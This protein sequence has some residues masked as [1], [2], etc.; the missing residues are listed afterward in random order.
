MGK[1]TERLKTVLGW[2]LLGLSALTAGGL[3]REKTNYLLFMNKKEEYLNEYMLVSLHNH[4]NSGGGDGIISVED[5]IEG[6]F[7]QKYSIC[8]LSEHEQPPELNAQ[9]TLSKLEELAKSDYKDFEIEQINEYTYKITKAD[10]EH[11][12]YML[13]GVEVTIQNDDRDAHVLGIGIKY[14]PDSNL[15]LEELL[16]DFSK[17]GALIGAPHPTAKLAFG[18]GENAITE[19]KE[20]FDFVELNGS[21]PFPVNLIYNGSASDLGDKTGIPVVS[22]P[23]AHLSELYFNK[24]LVLVEKSVDFNEEDL[25]GFLR[26]QFEEGNYKNVLAAE[27]NFKLYQWILLGTRQ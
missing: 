12:L 16:K 9:D 1:I 3:I 27:D 19:Y 21:L 8:S 4:S 23:D 24:A 26:S 6:A 2:S 22:F 15:N 10:C 13:Q 20:Y 18:L 25:V 14:V 17:Q 11:V 5:Y 7:N